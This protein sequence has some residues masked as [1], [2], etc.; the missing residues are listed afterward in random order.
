MR[1][2]LLLW[3]SWLC[4]TLASNATGWSSYTD[5]LSTAVLR[6]GEAVRLDALPVVI[7]GDGAAPRNDTHVYALGPD[8]TQ[9]CTAVGGALGNRTGYHVHATGTLLKAFAWGPVP[10]GAVTR[11]PGASCAVAA[12]L[13]TREPL[14]DSARVGTFVQ[15]YNVPLQH[16]IS[17][18]QGTL[19]P[20]L[21][22]T[23]L[24]ALAAAY[25]GVSAKRS[26]QSTLDA[27]QAS[28]MAAHC[29]AAAMAGGTLQAALDLK[30]AD[31]L[32]ALD[33][34]KLGS[35][36]VQLLLMVACCARGRV[37]R[38]LR[39]ES[40]CKHV[41]KA[42]AAAAGSFA[43]TGNPASGAPLLHAFCAWRRT[44]AAPVLGAFAGKYR[45]A[46]TTNVTRP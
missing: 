27:L 13:L 17:R 35:L 25:H 18:F 39:G 8:A 41:G 30:S 10:A 38:F 1:L 44:S 15:M 5:Q 46:A 4:E 20:W 6:S 37:L 16:E 11:A 32:A 31:N 34:I 40:S 42:V 45:Q 2:A 23:A 33:A 24:T 26:S 9:P 3:V 7:L 22:A 14:E 21:F 12:V 36:G 43:A 28:P 29:L 19:P